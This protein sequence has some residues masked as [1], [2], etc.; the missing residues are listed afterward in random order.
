MRQIFFVL[1]MI[2]FAAIAQPSFDTVSKGIHTITKKVCGYS[3]HDDST[4]LMLDKFYEY[5]SQGQEMRF[6][7]MH[8]Y[9]VYESLPGDGDED[10]FSEFYRHIVDE[11]KG[12]YK[13]SFDTSRYQYDA[14][15][16]LVKYTS[17]DF[18]GNAIRDTYAYDT[19]GNCI[20]E[21]FTRNGKE[22]YQYEWKYDAFN[23]V[24]SETKTEAGK[25]PEKIKQ[26]YY[27][28]ENRLIAWVDYERYYKDSITYNYRPDGKI[29]TD[30][31]SDGSFNRDIF[32]IH[33]SLISSVV[34]YNEPERKGIDKLNLYDSISI[35][36]NEAG[37]ILN[38]VEINWYN[39]GSD[40]ETKAYDPKGRCIEEIKNQNGKKISRIVHAW[41]DEHLTMTSSRYWI[42]YDEGSL[43]QTGKE[44]LKE[45]NI[46][47]YDKNNRLVEVKT[48]NEQGNMVEHIVYS[49]TMY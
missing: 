2:P 36:R 45:K 43:A 16:R 39:S 24:I 27:D 14:K 25:K 28:S 30:H 17:R 46:Y 35:H 34:Y 29:V 11:K 41:D 21:I 1:L 22:E 47:Q 38:S 32:D 37:L 19:N 6:V 49:Y 9:I 33:D 42:F 26:Y 4:G 40:T 10:A 12:G 48:I 31:K 18:S 15:F 3:G 23:H 5:N 44:I 7:R 20:K 13:H 8:L